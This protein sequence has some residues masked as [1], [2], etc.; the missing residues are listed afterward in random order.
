MTEREW[1]ECGNPHWLLNYLRPWKARSRKICLY[2]CA[3]C[4]RPDFW[5]KLNQPSMN[6]IEVAS[7]HADNQVRPEE[8]TAAIQA[9]I[10]RTKRDKILGGANGPPLYGQAILDFLR[11]KSLPGWGGKTPPKM[12]FN[13]M[14]SE[15]KKNRQG[16][17]ERGAEVITEDQALEIQKCS[18]GFM[19]DLAH[20]LHDIFGNPFRKITLDP[21]WLQRNKKSVIRLAQ[22]IYENSTFGLMPTLADVLEKAGCRD[23]EILDHCRHMG[24]HKLGCWV[25]DLILGK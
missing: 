8:Y 16:L 14:G 12:G 4:R 21:K 3:S 5:N 15:A 1:L 18:D 11:F 9:V 20:Y 17:R 22:N 24:E 23:V 10:Q 7:R 13:Y 6:L 2:V 19:K 25:L